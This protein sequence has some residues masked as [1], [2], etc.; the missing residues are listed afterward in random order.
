MTKEEYFNFAEKFMADCLEISKKKNADY[1]SGADPFLNFKSV[2]EE[3]VEIGFY[4]RMSDK[5]SRLRSFIRNGE[6]QVKD[7]SIKDTLMDLA[8]YSILLAGYLKSKQN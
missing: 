3:W 5:M 7:E 4:T 1:S 2:G 8:N 6:L